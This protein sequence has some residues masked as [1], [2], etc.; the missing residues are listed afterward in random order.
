VALMLAVA[1]VGVP[2]HHGVLPTSAIT[3][4]SVVD[5][6]AS[7]AAPTTATSEE[8]AALD[9]PRLDER[10]PSALKA[11]VERPA[12]DAAAG[13][14]A[15]DPKLQK[16]LDKLVS[17]L[18]K[19]QGKAA[20]KAADAA[21]LQVDTANAQQALNDAQ[22]MPEGTTAEA[23]SK[24]K[25]IK[26]ASS[27]FKK[28]QKKAEKA[29][30]AVAAVGLKVAN[31]VASIEE[32]DPGHFGGGGTGGGDG[33]GDD[34][35]GTAGGDDGPPDDQ[36]GNG[37]S[38]ATTPTGGVI[39]IPVL[40][41]EALPA[42]VVGHDRHHEVATFGIPL[43]NS[44]EVGE[45]MGRPALAVTGSDIYQF[46]TMAKWPDGAVKWALLDVAADVTAGTINNSIE[47]TNGD[48]RSSPDDLAHDD[49]SLI[50]IMN[51]DLVVQVSK[52][53]FNVFHRVWLGDTE[54]V[55]AG[56]S[57]GIVGTSLTGG[58]IVPKPGT[59]T[60]AI[61][62]NGPTR[63][64]IRADGMLHDLSGM[65]LCDF[66]C[67]IIAR[68]GSHDVQVDFTVRN[69]DAKMP[70]NIAIDGLGI[71]THVSA[72]DDVIGTVSKHNG[73][74]STP[75]GPT[76]WMFLHQAQS[77]AYT[78]ETV[79]EMLGQEGYEVVKNGTVLYPLGDKT[80][81]PAHGY[82]DL[83][84]SAG[85]MTVAYK[86]M[87]FESPAS[88]ELFGG[89]DVLTGLFSLRHEPGHNWTFGFR[90]HESRT[91][92]FSFHAPGTGDPAAVA[93]SLDLPVAGRAADYL[94]YDRAGVL[95]YRLVSLAEENY[96][97]SK[98]NINNYT[99]ASHNEVQM[100]TRWLYA[101]ES[102]GSNNY[103]SIEKH[104]GG[105]WLRQ[106]LGGP[107]LTGLDLALYKSEWQIVRS[108][109]FLDKDA[110]KVINPELTHD[111][112]YEGEYEHRYRDGIILAYWLTGDQRFKDALYDESE[113]LNHL[114]YYNQERGM[115][116]C[117]RAISLVGQFTGDPDGLLKA[118]LK[119]WLQK[120]CTKIV[121][122]NVPDPFLSGWG[123]QAAPDQGT[124]RFF[125]TNVGTNVAPP[126]GNNYQTRGFFTASLHPIAMYH[127]SRWLGLD[128]PQGAL[129]R[130]RMRDLAFYSRN[131]LYPYKPLP[132]DRWLTYTYGVNTM[133][134]YVDETSDAHPL[135]LGFGEAFK[136]TG[137]TGYMQR[138]VEEFQGF[139]AHD[140][141]AYA[142]NLY[143][144]ENRLDVQN[145]IRTYLEW[146]AA[147]GQ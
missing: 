69:A 72:G 31:Y 29:Q 131:E 122:I 48:G 121:D 107:Y 75:L 105:D 5:A 110:P 53:N 112:G 139:A 101:H 130:G 138:A 95:P 18:E 16:K 102:G 24:A 82:A 61:E 3:R 51:G 1:G 111:D 15:L 81:Y 47:I 55:A 117:L 49:G 66:T 73:P 86:Y 20:A 60:V 74:L 99:I 118:E 11:D 89:G 54:L 42:G 136:D 106:G 135:M 8:L 83:S 114:Y 141:G 90:Q 113:I 109:N 37:D 144:I 91:A 36:G 77:S 38:G 70:H 116:Q 125:A 145:F 68:A 21:K 132:K 115:A 12:L 146:L 79:N 84:G 44:D 35:G 6:A 88:L 59:V 94:Q 22:A 85:G 14:A 67:R 46:R 126:A 63:A 65:D 62:E 33:T 43:A 78:Y 100:V 64:V 27:L 4:D 19:E 17:K 50:S 56:A 133:I 30:V 142:N 97:F 39:S 32:I 28:L 143:G 80:K 108:D 120:F 58:L 26:K 147:T 34:T 140:Q 104:L 137:D 45:V 87:P 76:D 93:A 103:D 23:K 10:A 25:A 7:A 98:M 57:A 123:W 127:A 119:N 134:S 129:A 128:D 71:F 13:S 92:S 40:V 124:R 52:T 41:Q 2:R 9:A 96:A